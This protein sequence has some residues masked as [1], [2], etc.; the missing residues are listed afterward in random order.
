MTM[1]QSLPD[2]LPPKRDAKKVEDGQIDGG[3][4]EEQYQDDDEAWYFGKAK[5]D[6]RK[7]TTGQQADRLAEEDPIKV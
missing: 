6:L 4:A 5:E 1:D 7:R 2:L 3:T